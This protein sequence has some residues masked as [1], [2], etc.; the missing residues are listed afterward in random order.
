MPLKFEWNEKKAEANIRNHKVSF[1]EA[2]IPPFD[3]ENSEPNKFAQYYDEKAETV[4]LKSEDKKSVILDP[5]V[6]EY[7]S[8]SESVNTALRALITAF[9]GIKISGKARV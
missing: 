8:D 7:F 1:E 6:A 4:I 9:S 3:F 2:K 5:D